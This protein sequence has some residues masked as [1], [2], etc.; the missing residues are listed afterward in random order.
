MIL[1]NVLD[2]ASKAEADMYP[3]ELIKGAMA[4]H[5]MTVE[6]LAEKA[7]VSTGTVSAIRNGR[8][9]IMLPSLKAVAEAIGFEVEIRLIPKQEVVISSAAVGA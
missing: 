3:N 6:R 5:D 8:E 7:G 2:K 1:S 9:N 4:S